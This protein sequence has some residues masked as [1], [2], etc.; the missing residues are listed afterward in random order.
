M[1][2]PPCPFI[3]TRILADRASGDWSNSLTSQS[4][5]STRETTQSVK[6]VRSLNQVCTELLNSSPEGHVFSRQSQAGVK[7]IPIIA[8]NMA[9][10]REKTVARTPPSKNPGTSPPRAT[11]RSVAAI[12]PTI[13]SGEHCCL[14]VLNNTMHNTIQKPKTY[15][16]SPTKPIRKVF[17]PLYCAK[18]MK[19]IL[20]AGRAIESA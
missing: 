8:T 4:E 17:E 18:S 1:K 12:L 15:S 20:R 11:V 3:A 9:I 16:P 14:A 19:E 2:E 5:K 6:K 10:P 13:E 7:R